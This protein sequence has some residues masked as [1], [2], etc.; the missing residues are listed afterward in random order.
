MQ[1]PLNSSSTKPLPTPNQ[2]I[3]DK[4]DDDERSHHSFGNPPVLQDEYQLIKQEIN[5]LASELDS[6]DV[7]YGIHASKIDEI[8]L[9]RAKIQKRLQECLSKRQKL[10]QESDEGIKKLIQSKLPPIQSL[11]ISSYPYYFHWNFQFS[12]WNSSLEKVDF[13]WISTF[14]LFPAFFPH[15]NSTGNSSM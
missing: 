4:E 1:T 10:I 7:Q 6:I 14:P 15:W 3:Q 11:V 8:L 13:H 5:Q 2:L 9:Q 12:T